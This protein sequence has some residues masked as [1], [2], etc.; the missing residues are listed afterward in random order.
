MLNIIDFKEREIF[1]SFYLFSFRTFF[2]LFGT[3]Y[4][5]LII[6]LLMR[7]YWK[8]NNTIEVK[9]PTKLQRRVQ[10]ISISG[11]FYWQRAESGEDK[12]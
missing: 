5:M 4:F 2:F 6:L 3:L 11:R 9:E 8:K 12:T 7:N 1:L 10:D